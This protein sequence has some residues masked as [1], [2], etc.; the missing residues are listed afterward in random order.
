MRVH[1]GG[2]AGAAALTGA[3][4]FVLLAA[5]IGTDFWYII[6]TERLER[7]GPG[8]QDLLGSINRSQL[9]PLSSH[10][11]LW[12]TC[13]VQSPCTPLMNPFWLENVTVSE[14]S[15][16]LLT[17]H[18]T[19]VILLP[20]SLIL[21]VFGGMTGFLSFLLRAYLL[22]LL[23]GTLFLFGA[24]VT[25]AGIS[26]YIAYSAAAFREALCLLEEKALLDQVD[27]HFGWSLALGWISFIAELLTGGAFLAAARELSLRRRQDQAI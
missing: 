14:S 5:A 3:L 21:M 20:L 1:L 2:L 11:G 27:I 12:R 23:T 6:D 19:F 22:L 4:S 17:M 13:R 25:L 7:S 26:V 24:M 8:A 16:Q 15:R 18:G 10:S 9:E